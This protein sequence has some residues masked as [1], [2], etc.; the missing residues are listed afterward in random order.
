VGLSGAV[1]KLK[2]GINTPLGKIQ[3][4]GVDLSGGEWQRVAMARS[5][6]NYAPL[7][8]LDEPTAALEIMKANIVTVHARLK[9]R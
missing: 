4:D 6:V 3:A 9:S 2:N 1:E 8:I 5:V 7:K